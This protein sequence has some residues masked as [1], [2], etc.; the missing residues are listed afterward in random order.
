MRK[1]SL[2]TRGRH[3]VFSVLEIKRLKILQKLNK[4]TNFVYNLG[5]IFY[6]VSGAKADL[7]NKYMI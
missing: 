6:G 5:F 2:K 3:A 1:S 4:Q 7:H